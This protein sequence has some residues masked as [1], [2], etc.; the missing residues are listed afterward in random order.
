MHDESGS[1]QNEPIS[2]RDERLFGFESI[3]K[4]PLG[5]RNESVGIGDE[6]VSI[7]CESINNGDEFKGVRHWR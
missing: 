3:D 6:S 7:G 5:I 4:E 2:A 1:A